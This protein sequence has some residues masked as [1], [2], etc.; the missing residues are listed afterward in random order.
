MSQPTVGWNPL[1]KEKRE[2]EKKYYLDSG[3]R[4]LDLPGIP[5]AQRN[6]GLGPQN[7]KQWEE[8]MCIM[9]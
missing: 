9:C 4:N 7:Y 2:R 5:E 3:G 8:V 6:H 1:D